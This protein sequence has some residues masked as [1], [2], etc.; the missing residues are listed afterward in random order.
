MHND[1]D[2]PTSP[3]SAVTLEAVSLAV[4]AFNRANDTIQSL[5]NTM[6]P[7]AGVYQENEQKNINALNRML[8]ML[9]NVNTGFNAAIVS[10]G[11]TPVEHSDEII[12]QSKVQQL[13]ADSVEEIQVANVAAVSKVVDEEY[14]IKDVKDLV[15]ES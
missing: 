15:D 3:Q 13:V 6:L 1:L 5:K 4:D 12:S 8:V 2:L 10:N 11:I 9:D 14:E 7:M